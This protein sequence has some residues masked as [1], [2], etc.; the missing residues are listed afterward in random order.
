MTEDVLKEYL[1]HRAESSSKY[2]E[3]KDGV[4]HA[5]E[6][7]QCLRKLY[8]KRK[9]PEDK[10]PKDESSY[11]HFRLGHLIERIYFNALK[12]KHSYMHVR[13]SVPI[14]HEFD[15]F[16]LVGQT[17]PVILGENLKPK[18]IYEV[19]S[20]SN[21]KYSKNEPSKHHVF[22]VHPYIAALQCPCSIVYIQ[23]TNLSTATHEVN[24]DP[25]IFKASVDRLRELHKYLNDNKLPP[26][27]PFSPKFECKFCSFSKHCNKD[28][29]PRDID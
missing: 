10:I 19:K 9:A 14:R 1:R 25:S 12:H 5:S 17:D 20:T 3:T 7:S 8:Y 2:H 22:Q 13:N 4:Y 16:E 26:S 28:I 6:T 23:K 11:P 15:D 24:F 29:D 18:R 21:I 27:E